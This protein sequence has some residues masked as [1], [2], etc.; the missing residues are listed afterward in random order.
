MIETQNSGGNPLVEQ[1]SK[2]IIKERESPEIL[3][4]ETDMITSLEKL[5]LSQEEAL[6][7]TSA[8]TTTENFFNS[9]YKLEVERMK[10]LLKTYLRTRLF[11]IE[12]Y[13]L[14]LIKNEKFEL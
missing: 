12:K 9:I 8:S 14:Y 5:I 11:K 7:E 13:H 10:Y 4:Y 6:D 3:Q 1:I 2:A